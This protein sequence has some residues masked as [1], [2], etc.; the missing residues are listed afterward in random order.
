M[1]NED[2]TIVRNR[3]MEAGSLLSRLAS[4]PRAERLVAD[5]VLADPVESMRGSIGELAARS[6]TSP[7]TVMRLARRLGHAGFADWKIV[8]AQEHGRSSQFGHPD[9]PDGANTSTVL[10]H[11]LADDVEALRAARPCIDADVFAKA[12]DLIVAAP[13]ILFVGVGTS[14]A[15]AEIAAY[16]FAALGVRAN[17]IS[18]AL[19]QHLF[20]ST[21]RAGSAVVALSH[22]G[23]SKDTV[24]A[25]ATAQQRGATVIGITSSA[26]S[27]LAE[28]A[29]LVLITGAN[30][31]PKHL[32][33]FANRVVHLSLLGALHTAASARLA[34]TSAG[35]QAAKVVAAHQY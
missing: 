15:L 33:V 23:S 10:D 12:V 30:T 11:C 28:T 26:Q 19:G 1:L 16:R 3:G 8:L 27:P 4:L 14:G 20:A 17:T 31:T 25:A 22:T 13:E 9:L 35:I 5:A 6:G 2:G 24:I 29:D 18:D 34:S 32:D 21:L 7:A